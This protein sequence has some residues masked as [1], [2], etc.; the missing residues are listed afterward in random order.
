MPTE[1]LV[2]LPSTGWDDEASSHPLDHF[3]ADWMCEESFL[4]TSKI[5]GSAHTAC[6]VSGL[7]RQ[8]MLDS[9]PC[10]SFQMLTTMQRP[11]QSIVLAQDG[12]LE[13]SKGSLAAKERIDLLKAIEGD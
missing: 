11:V 2:S 6:H 12:L 3:R 9:G 5:A 13:A 8:L 10:T 7:T 1:L 4:G